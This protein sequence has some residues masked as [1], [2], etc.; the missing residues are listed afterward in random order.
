MTL[1]VG[2]FSTANGPGSLGMLESV[3]AAIDS[4]QLDVR[5][6]FV[7]VNR[8][9]GHSAATDRYMELV[10]SRG[11]PLVTLSSRDFRRERGGAPWAALREEFDC[12]VLSL[13]SGFRA[14]VSMQAGYMLYAPVLCRELLVLN[15]HPALPGT[16]VGKWQ[17]AVWDVIESGMPET[18]S[19][20]HVATEDLDSGP[21]VSYCRFPVTGPGWD[22]LWDGAGAS[23]SRGRISTVSAREG[24]RLGAGAG[25]SHGRG[26]G[27][28]DGVSRLFDAIR[29]AG[30]LRER[31]LVVRTLGAIA[32]GTV[33]LAGLRHGTLGPALD[34]SDAVESDVARLL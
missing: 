23:P 2:W 28:G 26:S 11:I 8:A 9:R 5:L 7:F 18:G 16:T 13:L 1:A 34:L 25:P 4:G 21:V 10:E 24:C 29:E 15:Q 31:P 33:P 3:L 22:S 6:E 14:D 17:D 20:V 27:G 12:E 19:M 32:D 30:L